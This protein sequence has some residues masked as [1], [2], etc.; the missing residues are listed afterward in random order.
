M[1]GDRVN[2]DIFPCQFTELAAAMDAIPTV[3]GMKD[4]CWRVL[5][6]I[7][8]LGNASFTGSGEDDALFA[9]LAPL[10]A[11]AACLGCEEAQLTKALCTQNIKA[12][13]DWIAK[14]N[15]TTY[16]QN[17]KDALSKALYSR[18]FDVLV[19]AI[20]TS[21]MFGGAS[22]YFIGAVDI[23]GFECFPHN[24]LEQ[25][26]INFANEKLQR[27]FTE[28]VFESIP[29]EYKKEGIEVRA[30]PRTAPIKLCGVRN[31]VCASRSVTCRTRTT[32]RW[33]SSSRI[34]PVASCRC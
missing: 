6:A 12:G 30:R 19:E 3:S 17:V 24:S 16:S 14:P 27:M 8:Q 1:K 15:T 7:M 20:N 21:L 25:L 31:A 10:R 2:W 32:H 22:R 28:A 34:L 33:S 13:L 23:F 29:A 4:G 11:A 5:I 9:D 18:L 26:C